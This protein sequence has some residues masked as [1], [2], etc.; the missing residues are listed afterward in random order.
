MPIALT[1]EAV[2]TL[3]KTLLPGS[4]D[5]KAGKPVD[6]AQALIAV[7]NRDAGALE[8]ACVCDFGMV[9]FGG[10]ALAM[11]P[12]AAAKSSQASGQ[13]PESI[14]ENFREIMNIAGT[15]VNLPGHPHVS[16]HALLKS[17]EANSPEITAL[18]A[19]PAGRLD[20]EVN[21]GNYGV[22]HISILMA[23]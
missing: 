7:Y 14:L 13:F 16:F 18:L 9:A 10:A 21:I 22:G 19:K 1:P 20:L 23:S 8:V 3:L 12:A 2:G 5:V 17:S 15:I 6:K 11:I 4:V